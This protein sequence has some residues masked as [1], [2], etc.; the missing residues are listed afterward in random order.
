MAASTWVVPADHPAFAGHFPGH[1]ILPGVV[2]LAE[3]LAA[4]EAAGIPQ[5]EG[6]VVES[7]KFVGAV[8]PGTRLDIDHQVLANGSVRFAM[9]AGERAVAMGTVSCPP[10]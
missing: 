1:P 8:A 5:A 4:L 10:R 2:L 3:V 6:W 9:R 7:V